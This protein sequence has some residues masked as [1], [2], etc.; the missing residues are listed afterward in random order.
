MSR[1]RFAEAI[2]VQPQYLAIWKA[3][4]EKLSPERMEL[5]LQEA[6]SPATERAEFKAA[7]LIARMMN[8]PYRGALEPI[9]RSIMGDLPPAQRARVMAAAVKGYT[10]RLQEKKQARVRPARSRPRS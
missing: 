10:Q 6:G 5:L 2:G 3:A 9:M 4:P 8:G 1:K 7:W